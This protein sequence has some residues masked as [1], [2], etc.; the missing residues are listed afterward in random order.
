MGLEVL[1]QQSGDNLKGGDQKVTIRGIVT[2]F[3]QQSLKELP[4]PIGFFNQPSNKYY[5]ISMNLTG[6]DK[7]IPQ[8]EKIW[9]SHYPD[10]PFHYFFLDDFYNAQ[11]IAD[12]RFSRLFL[13]SSVLAIIIACLGL[14]GLSAY[15]ISR[16]TKEIGIRKTNGSTIFQILVLLNSDFIRWVLV[17]IAI[18]TP[19]A[20]YALNKWLQNFAY[21]TTLSWWIFVI[22]GL[23]VLLIAIFTVSLQ[24]WK[25]AGNPVKALRYE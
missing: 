6:I 24:S 23:I 13:L 2:D 12:Y 18:A 20:W 11:Y 19:V 16:R 8:I 25:A 17:A 22:A 15:S 1:I 14:S 10:N 5:T 9:T 7:V 4:G 3:N 21:K